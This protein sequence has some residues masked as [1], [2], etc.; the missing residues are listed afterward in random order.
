MGSERIASAHSMWAFSECAG[1]RPPVLE[2][3]SVERRIDLV[4]RAIGLHDPPGTDGIRGASAHEADI[5]ERVGY[6]LVAGGSVGREVG[7]DVDGR[8]PYLARHRRDDLDRVTR[9]HDE[10][11]APRAEVGVERP[12]AAQQKRHSGR[13]GRTQQGLIEDEQRRH[14]PVLGVGCGQQRGVVVQTEVA[15]EPDDAHG[16]RLEP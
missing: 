8:R 9:T 4:G 11:P 5:A 15:A 13:S 1:L 10:P 14:R 6:P 16:P 7:A 12:Q 3:G 2:P